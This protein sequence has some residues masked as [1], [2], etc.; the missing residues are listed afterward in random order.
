MASNELARLMLNMGENLDI[1]LGL[2]QTAGK[3]LPKSSAVAD[4]L[5]WIYYRKGVYPLAVNYLQEA[6][7]LQETNKMPDNPDIHYRLG[8]AYEKTAQPALARQHFEQ[9]LKTNPN[10]P[11]AAEIKKELAHLKS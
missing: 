9:V 8:W 3:G 7:K 6:L 5:G 1:A 2:A 11:A 10:Y 4:T